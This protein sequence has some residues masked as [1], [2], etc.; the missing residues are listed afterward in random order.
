MTGYGCGELRDDAVE[1]ALGTLGGRGRADALAH[2]D[3]CPDCRAVVAGYADA[4]D[5]VVSAGPSLRP[6]RGFARKVVRELPTSAR[7]R[8]R[9]A[10]R[11]RLLV[12]TALVVLGL[13]VAVQL[14]AHPRVTPD[15]PTALSTP[16]VRVVRLSPTAHD[17]IGGVVFVHAT[18]PAWAFMA[19]SGDEDNGQYVCELVLSDGSTVRAGTVTMHDGAGTWREDVPGGSASIVGVNVLTPNGTLVAQ[20]TLA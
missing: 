8:P 14:P 19:V 7:P 2:L 16:G 15:V 4:V 5:A 1:L 20:A 6:P 12:A 13:A 9:P 17:D 3:R 18:S 10:P 11:A